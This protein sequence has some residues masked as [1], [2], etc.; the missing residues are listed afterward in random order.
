MFRIL[1][2][3]DN[4]SWQNILKL[5]I[6]NTLEK[7]NHINYK[8]Q[9]I[10]NFQEAFKA[11]QESSWN[12]V[13]TDIGLGNDDMKPQ[14]LGKQIVE[15][16]HEEKIPTIVVSAYLDPQEVGSL[17]ENYKISGFFWKETFDGIYFI[18]KVQE[19]LQSQQQPE[20]EISSPSNSYQLSDNDKEYL[21]TTISRLATNSTT[22]SKEYFKA[23]V[24]QLNLPEKWRNSI[25]DIWTGDTNTDT[26]KLVNWVEQKK[27]YPNESEKPGYT[28]LGS[29][30]EKLLEETGDRHF[31]EMI[32][33]YELITDKSVLDNLRNNYFE[34]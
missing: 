3:E 15:L 25:A 33:S 28:V 8:T 4:E 10:N 26:S 20:E 6:N 22:S 24:N 19:I 1:L 31:L 17:F 12:L 2:V 18:N 9:V 23:L 13:V 34:Q 27:S 7:I 21:I 11:L 29:L 30:I 16:A 32:I 14:K 5:K